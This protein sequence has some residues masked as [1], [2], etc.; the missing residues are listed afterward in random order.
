MPVGGGKAVQITRHRGQVAIESPDGRFVYYSV[1][2]GEGERDGLSGLRRVPVDG[3]EETDVL[4]SITFYN[5]AVVPEGVYFI[6][7]PDAEGRYT[8]HFFSFT[9]RKTRAVVAVSGAVVP[10][11]SVSPDGRSLLYGQIDE[12]RSDLMLVESLR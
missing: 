1:S 4:P 8:I 9:T 2:G 12:Q 6:P 7:R 5:F 10:G 3:G 11:L